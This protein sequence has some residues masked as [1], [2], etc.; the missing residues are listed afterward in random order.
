MKQ[1]MFSRIFTYHNLFTMVR[2]D[3]NFRDDLL[4]HESIAGQS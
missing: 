1:A 2:Q 4:W 3:W